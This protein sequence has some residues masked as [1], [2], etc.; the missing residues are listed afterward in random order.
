MAPECRDV[1]FCLSRDWLMWMT[2][3]SEPHMVSYA[4]R[5]HLAPLT[6]CGRNHPDAPKHE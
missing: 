4:I 5:T 1:T 2:T 6:H 3:S